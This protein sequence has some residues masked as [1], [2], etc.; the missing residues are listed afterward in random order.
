M[1]NPTFTMIGTNS[2][3]LSDIGS[4]AAP[5]LVD[6]DGDGDLDLLVGNA[7][8]NTVFF[9][10]NGTTLSPAFTLDSTNPFGI[11]NV[12]A[13]G[14][15]PGLADIDGDGDLDLFIGN[16]AG[17]TLFFRNNGT[18][19]APTFLLEG[20]GLFGIQ[21]AGSYGAPS[22][23]DLD[24][25]GD[26]DLLIG[27][28]NGNILLYRNNGSTQAPTFSLEATNPFG[29]AG[30]LDGYA[31]PALADINGDGLV[32][33]ITKSNV[34]VNVGTAAAPT[35]S[36]F[37]TNPYGNPGPGAY[38]R[39]AL[40]DLDGDGDRDLVIGVDGGDMEYFRNVAPVIVA[41]GDGGNTIALSQINT[42]TGGAGTD[43]VSLVDIGATFLVTGVETLT[44]SSATDLVMLGGGGNTLLVRRIET[45]TGGSGTDVLTL[46]TGSNVMTVN[47]VETING[48]SGLD[49]VTL[50]DS[51]GNTLTVWRLET[52][53]GNSGTD[54]VTLGSAGVTL[55]V[56]GVETVTGGLGTDMVELGSAGN[57]L[58]L[59]GIETL[60]GGIGTDVVTLGG[61]GNTLLVSSIETLAGSAGTDVVTL[62][63]STGNTLRVSEVETLIGG[64]GT[65]V[66]TF[67]P[68]GNQGTLFVSGVETVYTPFQTLT[69]NGVDTL[70][71]LPTSPST[72]AL[73]PASDSGV[74]GDAVTN[75]SQPTLTGTADAGSVL[76][77]Y[78]NGVEIGT[79]TVNGS[80]TWSMV[81]GTTLADGDWTLTA[82]VTVSGVESGESGPLLVTIDTGAS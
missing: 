76:H 18:A 40:G 63:D 41:L 9:R 10:N 49:I 47:G 78:G 75:A 60:A 17:T 67:S 27:N 32:D 14:A 23:A 37:A 42:L 7:D 50:G 61:G 1:A 72:P 51:A 44:G 31:S 82:K 26:L 53:I 56:D 36:L 64:S 66:V 77:L 54:V 74:I 30:D 28:A 4:E 19:Q 39:P 68:F 6:L 57:T 35:F 3:G 69:L 73:S 20:T 13:G 55:L 45:L 11:I 12:S 29:L 79:G 71:V 65:D 34:S 43:L 81:P 52:L 5:V 24:C 21:N 62:G 38:P 22:F 48:G 8:G 58:L 2:F 25:D 59:G 16:H 33:L 70:I 80:G 46:G 15:L